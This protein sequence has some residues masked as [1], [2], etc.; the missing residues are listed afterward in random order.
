MKT[1]LELLKER[2][3]RIEN[4]QMYCDHEWG[5]AEYDPE[6]EEITREEFVP[7]GVDSY[8]RAL[9]TGSFKDVDRWSRTCK[10]CC[11]KEYTYKM[12]EVAV[13]TEKRPKF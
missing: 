12:E 1:E 13:K 2:I 11:K 5:E 9:G 4:M 10:K 6:R 7:L 3:K 8:Y